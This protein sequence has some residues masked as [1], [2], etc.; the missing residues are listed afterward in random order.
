MRKS[1]SML[2]KFQ[3]KA[4]SKQL[5]TSLILMVSLGAMPALGAESPNQSWQVHGF[6][7]QGLIG[8]QGSDFVNDEENTSLKLTEIGLN[9]TYQLN[10]SLRIA[11]QAVYLN[12][13]NRYAEG[14]RIDYLLADWSLY[15]S[16]H[17]QANLYIGRFKTYHWLYSSTRDVPMT[18]PSIIL[19]QS[20]YF[21]GTR[22]LSVG[23]DGLALSAKHFSDTWGEF[24]FNLSSGISPISDKQTKLLMGRI[25]K[26]DLQHDND[27]QASIYWQPEM[28]NWRLG[29]ALTDGDFSYE[30]KNENIFAD[31]E[32][33]LKR[34]YVNGEYQAEKW[35]FSFELLQE[36]LVLDGLLFPTFY[37]DTTGQGGF[38]QGEYQLNENIK[39]LT[40]YEHYYGNKDDKHGVQLEKN[41]FG[42]VPHYFGYQHDSVL[43]VTYHLSTN[44]QIQLEHHWVK[45]TA[46]LTPVVFPDP[47]VNYNKYWHISALQFITWF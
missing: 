34:Y 12:G 29:I 3:Y 23:G 21:D 31:G 35:T 28:S 15:T 20:V 24:D 25:S 13:G 2:L 32:L 9:A 39:L 22:D 37:S 42:Y 6:L 38:V 5:I 33:E 10:D 18:R 30:T 14:V 19:P 45:G 26:G 36:Q 11:G 17:W 1:M 40:R 46:R 16:E 8:V 27:L 43:G 4:V 44:M 47:T 41:S 7:A